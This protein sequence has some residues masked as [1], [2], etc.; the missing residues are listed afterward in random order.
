MG[1]YGST[2]KPLTKK[3][4]ADII[5]FTYTNKE[6]S[7][8][9]KLAFYDFDPG[10]PKGIQRR[11]RLKVIRPLL[12]HYFSL[13]KVHGK[14]ILCHGDSKIEVKNNSPLDELKTII[15]MTKNDRF[16]GYYL[17]K[18]ESFNET[19]EHGSIHLFDPSFSYLK[20]YDHEKL[21]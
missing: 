8:D 13:I 5:L 7:M 21:W 1:A 10:Q 17:E 18:E 20:I 11:Y 6:L 15:E 4:P 16:D 12:L 19:I 2:I 3:I 9:S 14:N